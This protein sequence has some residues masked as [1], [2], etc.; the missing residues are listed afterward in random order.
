MRAYL[1][2][3]WEDVLFEMTG[4]SGSQPF[5]MEDYVRVVD[6]FVL[7]EFKAFWHASLASSAT[8]ASFCNDLSQ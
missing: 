1:F 5:N 8:I 7:F 6:S 4:L 3:S 2:L